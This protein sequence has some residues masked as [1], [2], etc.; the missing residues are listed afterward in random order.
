MLTH[1]HGGP[2]RLKCAKD[3]VK[4]PEGPPTRR[5]N[6]FLGEVSG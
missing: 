1:G 4:S 5:L 2:E 3:E 6:I